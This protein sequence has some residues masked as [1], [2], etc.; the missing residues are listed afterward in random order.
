MAKAGER[1][2][3]KAIGKEGL[4]YTLGKP[5]SD[6]ANTGSLLHDI[7]AIF[8]LLPTPPPAKLLDLG[9]GSGWTSSFFAQAGYDVTGVDIAPEAI[10]AAKKHFIKPGL[11]LTYELSDYDTLKYKNAFDAVIFFDSLHHAEDE[12]VALKAAYKALKPGGYM[13]ACE[14][15]HGHS[16]SPTSVEA[17]RKYGVNERDMPP[18][19]LKVQA[20]RAG[21]DNIQVYAYPALAHRALYKTYTSGLKRLFNNPLGRAGMGLAL[22]TLLRSQHGIVVGQKPKR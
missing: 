15:G 11:K 10:V 20:T 8:T 21:F 14:P 17:V 6:P 19:L 12:L 18:K 3:F 4:A 5:F 1:T 2:Y 22:S 16:K 13:I 7:A 9:V